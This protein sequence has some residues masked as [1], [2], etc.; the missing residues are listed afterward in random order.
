MHIGARPLGAPVTPNDTVRVA[1][2][3]RMGIRV[4]VLKI[5][6]NTE[7]GCFYRSVKKMIFFFFPAR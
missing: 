1:L 3:F 5:S 6:I 2:D 7:H 4:A